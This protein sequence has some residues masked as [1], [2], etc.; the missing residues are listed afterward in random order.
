MTKPETIPCDSS[1]IDLVDDF[2]L[3]AMSALVA[4]YAPE[5]LPEDQETLD[6]WCDGIASSAYYMAIAMMDARH[7]A[8]TALAQLVAEA[9]EQAAEESH[10]EA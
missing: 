5:T 7:R 1:L 4:S 10:A 6:N 8:H 2:A 3:H 9:R